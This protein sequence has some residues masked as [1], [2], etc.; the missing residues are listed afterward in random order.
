MPAKD[1]ALDGTSSG[2]GRAKLIS[3]L[4]DF[5]QR[6]DVGYDLAQHYL[7]ARRDRAEMAAGIEPMA[8]T[9]FTDDA[10]VVVV[11]FG[12]P[13][14]YVRAAVRKL[15]ADGAKVGYVRPITLVPFPTE[16]VAA[17]AAGRAPSPS[18]RTTRAR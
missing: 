7:R 14:K 16:I 9:G 17:A 15:R 10:E 11:A 3:P 6:D 13:G 4:G 1:W 5:K 8:E 2:T 18:T 12:T